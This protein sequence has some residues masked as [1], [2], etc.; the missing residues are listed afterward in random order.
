MKNKIAVIRELSRKLGNI[1]VVFDKEVVSE[2]S[3]DE[4]KNVS[5]RADVVVFAESA[6][7]V[8]AVLK[9]CT[10][11]KCPVVTRGLGSGVTGGAVPV[12]GG[13]ILSA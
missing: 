12:K 9:I 7:D 8:S 10:K 6:E 2:Y 1:K 11:H 4:T 13:V 5:A 3:R